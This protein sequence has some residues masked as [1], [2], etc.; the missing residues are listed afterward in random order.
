[1][2]SVGRVQIR[3]PAFKWGCKKSHR[4]L[5]EGYGDTVIAGSYRLRLAV[6]FLV[7]EVD[8]AMPDG[9]LQAFGSARKRVTAVTWSPLRR[10]GADLCCIG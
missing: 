4:Q 9:P 2:K 3:T 6:I 7:R 10:V 8:A 5:R 1:L